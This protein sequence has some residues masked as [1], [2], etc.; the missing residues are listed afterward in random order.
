MTT[1]DTCLIYMHVFMHQRKLEGQLTTSEKIEKFMW[2][3]DG[4]A[5]EPLSNTLKNEMVPYE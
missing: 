5:P 2:F 1:N 3:G 4:D